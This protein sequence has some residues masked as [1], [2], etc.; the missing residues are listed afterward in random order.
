MGIVGALHPACLQKL[1]KTQRPPLRPRLR[2][3]PQPQLMG[4]PQQ[5]TES[6]TKWT[7]SILSNSG[8]G[9]FNYFFQV[10]TAFQRPK[11]STLPSKEVVRRRPI[12]RSKKNGT[13]QL[14]DWEVILCLG[15]LVSCYPSLTHLRSWFSL[16]H[17]ACSQA[18]SSHLHPQP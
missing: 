13:G 16:I 2:T 17:S 15:S 3:E 8:V 1:S 6:S 12:Q 18:D 11:Q 9:R 14:W 7:P 10:K 4:R 5:V